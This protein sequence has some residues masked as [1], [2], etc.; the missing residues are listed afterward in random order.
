MSKEYDVMIKETLMKK[1]SVEAKNPEEAKEKIRSEWQRGEHILEADDFLDVEFECDEPYIEMTYREM[2][3]IFYH[4]NKIGHESV[5]GYIVF[6]QSSFEKTYSEESR[7]YA[8]SSNNKAYISGMGG[9]SIYGS[10]L[11]GT[12]Q[13][14]RLEDV[15]R[16]PHSWKIEKCYMHKD[17]YDELNSQPVKEE[18]TK[19]TDR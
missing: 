9:Y 17:V 6:D 1:V 15:I 19:E 7:T 12:D 11:D 13:N 16:G 8:I 2:S 5:S 10:C 18:K 3:D 4:V 14:I